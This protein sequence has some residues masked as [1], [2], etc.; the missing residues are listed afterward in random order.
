MAQLEILAKANWR[1]VVYAD[2]LNLI[3]NE[4]PA[5]H[6]HKGMVITPHPGEL[7]RLFP[8]AHSLD[9][10][11]TARQF[12]NRHP[13]TLLYKGARTIITA[14]GEALSYNCT[15]T[16]AMATGGQGDVLTGLLGALLAGGLPSLGAAQAAAWLAGRASELAQASGESE[17][18]L[19]AS[20]TARELGRAFLALRE[21]S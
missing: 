2:A 9:R 17:Q 11:E 19:L 5:N 20:D 10:A 18:S 3:A 14:P 7:L 8:E 6:D 12:V 1:L 13:C 21:G 4:G 15:G 16:P